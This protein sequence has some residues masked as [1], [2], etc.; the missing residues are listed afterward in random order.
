LERLFC[1]DNQIVDL[2]PLQEMRLNLLD[3]GDNPLTSIEPLRGMPLE[4][5]MIDGTPVSDL[6]PIHDMPL[7]FLNIWQC[8]NIS[9]FSILSEMDSLENLSA[10]ENLQFK[11]PKNLKNIYSGPGFLSGTEKKTSPFRKKAD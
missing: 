5:L 10:P 3:V 6:S 1:R 4:A 9:D 8:S 7:V 2:A 11:H